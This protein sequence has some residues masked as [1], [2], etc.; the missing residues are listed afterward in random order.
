ML[1]LITGYFNEV[2]KQLAYAQ[3]QFGRVQESASDLQLLVLLKTDSSLCLGIGGSRF[4]MRD[5]IISKR[6]VQLGIIAYY[7]IW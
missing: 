6:F 2:E 1:L 3:Y 7:Q 4:F 5:T